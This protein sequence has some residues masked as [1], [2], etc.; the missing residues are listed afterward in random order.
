ML[1]TVQIGE[2]WLSRMENGTPIVNGRLKRKKLKRKVRMKTRVEPL[3][4]LIHSKHEGF[5][6]SRQSRR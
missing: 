5:E 4:G 6:Y 3:E 2:P 1:P